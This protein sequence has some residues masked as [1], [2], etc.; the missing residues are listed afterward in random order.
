MMMMRNQDHREILHI[1]PTNRDLRR[2]C[3][4]FSWALKYLKLQEADFCFESKNF[5]FPCV[6]NS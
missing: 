3:G 6:G 4:W 2:Q 1:T 5:E